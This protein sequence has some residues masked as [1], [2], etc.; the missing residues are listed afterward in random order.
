MMP[1]TK[2]KWGNVMQVYRKQAKLTGLDP[3]GPVDKELMR[4]A[5]IIYYNDLALTQSTSTSDSKDD[6]SSV[7]TSPASSTD[8]DTISAAS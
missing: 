7:S 5:R 1:G 6:L 4:T 8:E 2:R 3:K